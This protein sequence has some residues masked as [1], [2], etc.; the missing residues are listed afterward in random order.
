MLTVYF[1]SKSSVTRSSGL[2][3]GDREVKVSIYK[4]CMMKPI[5]EQLSF[6]SLGVFLKN[7]KVST[8][9]IHL[10]LHYAFFASDIHVLQQ[11]KKQRW[12][13][14]L[15]IMLDTGISTLQLQRR[16]RSTLS[17]SR[18]TFC[19]FKLHLFYLPYASSAS[20]FFIAQTLCV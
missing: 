18:P 10:L 16:S 17:T 3:F 11:K 1:S 19:C 4:S 12:F 9:N 5:Q 2:C 6:C 15:E 8:V 7:S 14:S 13:T 20:Q